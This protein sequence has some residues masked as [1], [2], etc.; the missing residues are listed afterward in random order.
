MSMDTVSR[1]RFLSTVAAATTLSGCATLMQPKSTISPLP[2]RK[3]GPDDKINV[4]VIGVGGRGGA[5]IGGLKDENI[6]ALCDVD[7]GQAAKAFKAHPKARRFK[8]FRVMFDEMADE[9][10]AVV[11]ATPDHTHAIACLA[12]LQLRKH[13]YCEKPLAHSVAEVRAVRHAAKRAGVVTQL[14]NQGHSAEHIRLL[15]EWV[16]DGAIGDVPLVNL[17]CLAGE[18]EHRY[19]HVKHLPSLKET[20]EIPE[21]LDWDL[22]QGPVK[23]RGF[24]PTYAPKLWRGWQAFGCGSLGDWFCHVADPS[25]WALDLDAPTTVRAE[26]ENYDQKKHAA[27]FPPVATITYEFPAKGKRGPVTLVWHDGQQPGPRPEELEEGR[28]TPTRGGF[29]MGT[30]GVIM[31]GSH[32]AGGARIIPEK[33]MKAYKQPE[34]TI[35]R[36]KGHHRDFTNAIREGREAGSN[37]EFGGPLTEAALLGV[38]AMKFPGETLEWDAK[39]MR[40]T[41]NRKANKLVTPRFYNGWTL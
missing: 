39:N 29:L 36:T 15:C 7:D 27:T 23:K 26:V 18:S 22:W 12:A 25:W 28:K 21:G 8:D 34:K 33:A 5:S 13:L 38:I 31:H 4:A 16:W 17:N 2:P 32:G 19:S 14:G 24:V 9:I 37:F 30:K 41:N 6:V 11:V 10:D 40:I 3:I 20:H 35:P 1:R